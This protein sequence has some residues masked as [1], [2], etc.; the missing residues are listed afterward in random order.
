M[1]GRFMNI[2][3]RMKTDF[4]T[5]VCCAIDFFAL[6]LGVN[7]LLSSSTTSSTETENYSDHGR[8]SFLVIISE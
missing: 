5:G 1:N 2:L 3:K 6:S 7:L 8:V 4:V